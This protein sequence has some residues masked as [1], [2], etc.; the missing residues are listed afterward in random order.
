MACCADIHIQASPL[1]RE[2]PGRCSE[3]PPFSS[4][5]V[6]GGREGQ[7]GGDE[8]GGV[9][10]WWEGR[11][12]DRFTRRDEKEEEQDLLTDLRRLIN[13][14]AIDLAILKNENPNVLNKM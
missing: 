9:K 1:W 11:G 3:R 6:G 4:E 2:T 10:E 7:G 14:V 8:C 5:C 13:A 12:G